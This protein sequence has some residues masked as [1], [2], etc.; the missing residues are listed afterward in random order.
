MRPPAT[1]LRRTTGGN[2]A[3]PS[4]AQAWIARPRG[5]IWTWVSSK[6]PSSSH[7]RAAHLQREPPP[8]PHTSRTPPRRGTHTGRG[9]SGADA[10]PPGHRG[11]E[12]PALPRRATGAAGAADHSAGSPTQQRHPGASPN[13][14]PDRHPNLTAFSPSRRPSSGQAAAGH[15][16]SGLGGSGGGSV[17]E[18]PGGSVGAAAGFGGR[19]RGCGWSGPGRGG[20]AG[21]GGSGAVG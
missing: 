17:A 5:F 15:G 14:P 18:L 4:N 13:S 7:Q 12:H 21:G 1:S 6:P 19:G 8:G 11:G 9:T 2:P 10:G 16:F 20:F 3:M